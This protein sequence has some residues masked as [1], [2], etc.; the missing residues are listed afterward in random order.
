M[1]VSEKVKVISLVVL[2]VLRQMKTTMHTSY[3]MISLCLIVRLS[4][5]T[6]LKVKIPQN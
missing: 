3:L 1:H 2:V 5:A 4:D 6:L